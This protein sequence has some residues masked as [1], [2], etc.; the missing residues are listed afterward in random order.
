MVNVFGGQR[1]FG[2]GLG[3]IVDGVYVLLRYPISAPFSS[4]EEDRTRILV[5]AIYGREQVASQP[6]RQ[7][8]MRLEQESDRPSVGGASPRPRSVGPAG[9]VGYG[10]A[11][12][13]PIGGETV[14]E[15][16]DDEGGFDFGDF[17]F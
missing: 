16:G 15:G 3:G 17:D 1:S 14:D 11:I 7:D 12:S 13:H 2:G 10:F 5:R 6:M 9:F 4:Q 8:L